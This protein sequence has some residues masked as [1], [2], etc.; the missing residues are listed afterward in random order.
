[1]T[2]EPGQHKH[3]ENRK[4][5]AV[6]ISIAVSLSIIA[7]VTLTWLILSAPHPTERTYTMKEFIDLLPHSSAAGETYI[8]E[9]QVQGIE[10]IVTPGLGWNATGEFEVN[11]SVRMTFTSVAFDSLPYFYYHFMGDRV[12]EFPVEKHVRFAI[13]YQEW[14]VGDGTI[15]DFEHNYWSYLYD[16]Y[17]GALRGGDFKPFEANITSSGAN[18]TIAILSVTDFFPLP[19]NWRNLTVWF[20]DS[21]NVGVPAPGNGTLYMNGTFRGILV[22]KGGS[23]LANNS[24]DV[25]FGPNQEL[26]V[27]YDGSYSAIQ[28][29]TPLTLGTIQL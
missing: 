24:I 12:S 9:D 26:I 11:S 20:L 21:N 13:I 4:R 28:F 8:I 7:A 27:P 29:C 16:G 15:V 1:M 23:F 6:I 19:T 25:P 18:V 17:D 14:R 5:R 10:R 22:G 3:A 2:F